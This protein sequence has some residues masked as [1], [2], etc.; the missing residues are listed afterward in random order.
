MLKALSTLV[1]P[2]LV[3]AVVT[4]PAAQADD[5]SVGEIQ[6]RLVQMRQ[7]L[8]ALYARSAAA[9]EQLNGATVRLEQARTD[10]ERRRTA[11]QRAQASIDEYR[12]AVATMTVDRLQNHVAGQALVSVL[13]GENPSDMLQ[14]ASAKSAADEAMTAQLDALDGRQ[15]VLDAATRAVEQAVSDQEQARADQV[16][17][18]RSIQD[19]IERAEQMEQSTAAE[20]DSLLRRLAAAQDRSVAAVTKT[21]DRLDER[22]DE[23]GPSAAP[24]SP[25]PA[26]SAPKPTQQPTTPEPADP[27]APSASKVEKAIAY[28]KAQLGEKYVWGG[29]GPSS[30]DCSGLTMRAWQAAGVNLSHYAGSQYTATKRVSVSKIKRGDLLFWSDGSVGSIYHVALYLGG[31]QMIH[32]PRPGRTVEIVPLSYWIQPDLAS[33]PG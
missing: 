25:D 27:P 15:V 5:P 1:A 29:A 4:A 32:A 13:D 18:R 16:A 24:A 30:W 21:Q 22:V 23:S 17:A 20:R 10:L 6:V 19:S 7:D 26:P 14:E 2:L 9:S 11:Q 31:G 8:N 28:A 33:R 12:D 3:I